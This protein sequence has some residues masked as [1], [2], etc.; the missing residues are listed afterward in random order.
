MDRSLVEMLKN[1]KSLFDENELK[2][3][4]YRMCDEDKDS[5]EKDNKRQGS[6]HDKR[7]PW[8]LG[9]YGLFQLSDGHFCLHPYRCSRNVCRTDCR[10]ESLH[11]RQK[12]TEIND[13]NLELIL[14]FNN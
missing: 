9:L 14:H 1:E 7:Q 6:K 10:G 5:D 2:Q 8:S 12:K 11:E 3:D 13:N 4:N